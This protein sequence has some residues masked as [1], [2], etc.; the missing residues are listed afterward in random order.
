MKQKRRMAALLVALALV[1]SVTA[2]PALATETEGD[3]PSGYTEMPQENTEGETVLPE[4]PAEEPSTAPDPS[5]PE[6][7]VSSDPSSS[8]SENESSSSSEGSSSSNDPWEGGTTSDNE[9]SSSEEP[10][11]EPSSSWEEPVEPTE[12]PWQEPAATES[13]TPTGGG[14]DTDVPTVN[15]PSA[16]ATPRPSLER[17]Q[18][19]LNAGSSSSQ[20]EEDSG[21][22]YVTFARLN[23]KGNSL[24]ATLF[25]SGVG[26]I[27]VGLVGLIA[28]LAFYIRGRRRYSSADG[29][30][31]EIHEAEVRQQPA[32]KLPEPPAQEPPQ[33]QPQPQPMPPQRP[34]RQVPPGAIMPEEVSLYT[35]EFSL[36]PQEDVP[37]G[38][39][40][41]EYRDDY[42]QDVYYEDG[43]Y[44]DEEYDDDYYEDVDPAQP[45]EPYAAPPAQPAPQPQQPESY[46]D[47]EA[48]RQF[49]TEEILR[50]ALRYTED[51]YK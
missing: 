47:Q 17:P 7:P 24:A 50:E 40:Y 29:I 16:I 22:N 48:T 31:E 42:P 18:V 44:D 30:L 3:L 6:P 51:D 38:E 36:P 37:Y 34:A 27:A 1:A 11:E 32:Q 45:A 8:S 43:Y 46:S 15:E 39:T 14:T 10:W 41:Q 12:E 4:E 35:E 13:E 20:E 25:Y 49:D 21:P 2:I 9:G 33:P 26:C 19:S 5:T 23:I 28:I